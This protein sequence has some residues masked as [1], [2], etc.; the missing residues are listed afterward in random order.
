MAKLPSAIA[1]VSAFIALIVFPDAAKDSVLSGL[2]LCAELIIPSLFPFFVAGTLLS[3]LGIAAA[4][5]KRLSPISSR[6][7]GA[8]G[9]GTSAFFIGISGGYPIGASY[10]AELRRKGDIS[11]GEASRLLVFCNNSGPAFIIGAAGIGVFR[12]A[13]AGLLLY[14]AHIVAA[15]TWG[16]ILRGKAADTAHESVSAASYSLGEALTRSVKSSVSA[17]L[18]VC[19]FVVAFSVLTGLIDASGAVSQLAGH[20]SAVLGTELHWSRALL[21]GLLE[22]GNGI[23]TMQGLAVSPVNLALAAFLLGWGGV[24]VYFQ[25][26]SVIAGTDIKTARYLTGRFLIAL[27]AAAVALLG[28][29]VFF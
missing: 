23:G 26:C 27:T 25:T 6:L 28:A 24:S 1:A 16:I 19:G 5:G 3:E 14:A 7:F 29:A 22:L 20:L 12:S 13:A 8:S 11:S 15:L 2:R 10:I 21:T 17:V 9:C 18:S 4:L